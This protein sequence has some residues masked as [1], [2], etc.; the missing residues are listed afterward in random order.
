[1]KLKSIMSTVYSTKAIYESRN[2]SPFLTL[3]IGLIIGILHFTP[4]TLAF[5]EL[6]TYIRH[7]EQSWQLTSANQENFTTYFPANCVI[8]NLNLTCNEMLR[9]TVNEGTE[10]LINIDDE[11]LENG[12]ILKVDHFIFVNNG[13]RETFTYNVFEG[14]NFS[15]LQNSPV[16]Y[17]IFMNRLA[18]ALRNVLVVSFVL[19]SYFTGIVSYFAFIITISILSM[20]LKFGHTSFLKFK[21]VLSI[22][23]FSSV[24]PAVLVIV[25]GFATP[26]F[27]TLIFNFGTPVIA[28]FVYKMYVIPGLQNSTNDIKEKDFKGVV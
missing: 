13:A 18:V 15:Y 11:N 7:I 6:P 26:A 12:L 17:E 19:G 28:W 1:M 27:T 9:V 5:I 10:I 4:H 24:M 25:I 22:L 23:V 3:L 20:L 8:N 16:G 2:A 14:I 21:E